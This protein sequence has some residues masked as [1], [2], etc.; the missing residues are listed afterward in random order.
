MPEAREILC[1]RASAMNTSA[2][3]TAFSAT[4]PDKRSKPLPHEKTE[5]IPSD[6]IKNKN[7][8]TRVVFILFLVM[9]FL[10][11]L[12]DSPLMV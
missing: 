2:S 5:Y 3:G 10:F 6:N 12:T 4:P 7:Y 9:L 1:K 8:P 11:P